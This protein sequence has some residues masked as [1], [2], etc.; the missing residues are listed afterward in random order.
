MLSNY[1]DVAAL[2]VGLVLPAIV[3][4]F[5]KPSTNTTVKTVAH[6]VLAVATGFYAVWQAHP[7]SAFLAP[8]LVAS[9]LAWVT[10]TVFYQ[11]V[12][13]RYGWM[14]ALQ[15][16][17]VKDT[18]SLFHIGN[19]SVGELVAEAQAGQLTVPPGSVVTPIP[20]VAGAALTEAAQVALDT[21]AVRNL[22][23][24]NVTP[25]Q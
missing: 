14:A 9:I 10:G 19:A 11:N 25:G 20:G 16:T 23:A 3:G 5:T 17:L 6:A 15:N 22:A 12:L 2:V 8:A 7:Q 18:E 4:L 24:S 13:K 1:A 21:V